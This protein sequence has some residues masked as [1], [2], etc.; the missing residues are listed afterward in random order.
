MLRST[1]ETALWK[2]VILTDISRSNHDETLMYFCRDNEESDGGAA[3]I[4]LNPRNLNGHATIPAPPPAT[5]LPLNP[6]LSHSKWS[7][8]SNN[9]VE[10]SEKGR[11]PSID[12]EWEN[13]GNF[14][15]K[16]SFQVF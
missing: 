6:G 14:K 16:V 10:E 8:N 4:I 11:A 3:F 9:S 12:L 5:S 2:T 13:D 15:S 1:L 7:V